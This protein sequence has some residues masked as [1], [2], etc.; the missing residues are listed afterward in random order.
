MRPLG[1][2]PAWVLRHDVS[3]SRRYPKMAEDLP[4]T[5]KVAKAVQGVGLLPGTLGLFKFEDRGVPALARP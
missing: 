3:L 2:T 4:N 1:S 5:G